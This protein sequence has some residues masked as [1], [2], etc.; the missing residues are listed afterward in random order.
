MCVLYGTAFCLS[1]VVDGVFGKQTKESWQTNTMEILNTYGES[2]LDIVA[3]DTCQ[4]PCIARVSLL[5]MRWNV[6]KFI[7]SCFT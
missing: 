2:L 3:K 7:Q 1:G 4:G 6:K 5:R